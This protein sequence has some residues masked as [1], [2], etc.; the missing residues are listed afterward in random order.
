[1]HRKNKFLWY[2]TTLAFLLFC[3]VIEAIAQTSTEIAEKTLGS[4]VFLEMKDKDGK[5]LGFGSGFFV[6][7]EQIA[8]C[9]HVIEGGTSG[10]IK[11]V[12][13][14]LEFAIEGIL[15]SSEKHDL[16]ILRV[17]NVN[18][19]SLLLGDSDSVQI[20][21]EIYAA[22]NPQLLLKDKL[23]VLEGTIMPGIISANREGSTDGFLEYLSKNTSIS[24][25]KVLQMS[26]QIYPGCSGGPVLNDRGEVIGI[27]FMTF[28][29]ADFFNFAIP[30]NYLKLLVAR[31]ESIKPLAQVN[32]SI[33]AYTYFLWGHTKFQQKRYAAAIT[34]FDETIRLDPDYA[35]AYNNRGLAKYELGNRASALADFD[36]A[37]RLNHDYAE[38][39]NNKGVVMGKR[40]EHKSAIRHFDTAIQLEP[41]LAD[42]YHNRGVMKQL[43]GQHQEAITDYNMAIG[44]SLHD[45]DRLSNMAMFTDPLFNKVMSTALNTAIRFGPRGPDLTDV[46]DIRGTAPL[47]LDAYSYNSARFSQYDSAR[48]SQLKKSR[49]QSVEHNSRSEST[50]I[51]HNRGVALETVIRDIYHNRGVAKQL[52]GQHKSA[53]VDFD[54]A[55]LHNQAIEWYLRERRNFAFTDLSRL[56]YENAVIALHR[57]LSKTMQDRISEARS[58]FQ[59]AMRLIERSGDENLGIILYQFLKTD[60]KSLKTTVEEFLQDMSKH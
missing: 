3:T 45:P 38:A 58:D 8:T 5:P 46:Y 47:L 20:G 17:S 21:E 12:N 2:L 32:Q 39:H 30:S 9:F 11:L 16:A 41:N 22:G 34:D 19:T 43:L 13:K 53:I 54:N 48:L 10:T 15:A 55:L 37:I 1:M 7:P 42:A 6:R 28:K 52:L 60:N 50:K 27:S 4:L 24:L 14:D 51:Y 35:Y 25:D 31:E 44:F 33:P 36:E 57:G 56:N 23:T 29:G 26:A 59:T 40:G 18:G 49:P